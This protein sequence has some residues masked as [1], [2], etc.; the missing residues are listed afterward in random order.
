M[1]RAGAKTLGDIT[2]KSGSRLQEE[3]D[4]GV[5]KRAAAIISEQA[6]SEHAAHDGLR[7]H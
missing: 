4:N 7:Q 1:L 6:S 3:R 5:N 2:M